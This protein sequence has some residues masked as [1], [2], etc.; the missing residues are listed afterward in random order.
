MDGA[1]VNYRDLRTPKGDLVGGRAT[2]TEAPPRGEVDRV[3]SWILVK[4]A[5]KN[6][7]NQFRRKG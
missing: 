5:D 4:V 2:W 3:V 7:E 6:C 1:K